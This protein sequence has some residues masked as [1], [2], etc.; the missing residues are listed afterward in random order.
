MDYDGLTRED[1]VRVLATG[2]VSR[3]FTD[4]PRGPRYEMAGRTADGRE[5]RTIVRLLPGGTVRVI[6]AYAET[7]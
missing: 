7:E 4:D 6:T 5:A 1:V 3:R 2:Q